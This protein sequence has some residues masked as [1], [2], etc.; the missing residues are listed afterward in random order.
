MVNEHIN[1]DIPV[2]LWVAA[3]MR[4]AELSGA[5]ATIAH[6]GDAE[7]GDV[8][9][10]VTTERGRAQLYA[11][12]PE[13]FGEPGDEGAFARYFP[14]AETVEESEVDTVIARRLG[15]DWDLWVIEIEDRAGRSFLTERI[16]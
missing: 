15:Y 1:R 9:V 3:L 4:R 5:F 12:A 10:K 16:R 2:H 11:P 14:D 7:R 13:P 8:L 6:K